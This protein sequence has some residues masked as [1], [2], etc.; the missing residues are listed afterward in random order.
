MGSVGDSIRGFLKDSNLGGGGVI[1]SPTPPDQ[2]RQAEFLRFP[3]QHF[4]AK[5]KRLCKSK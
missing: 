5:E 4:I 3:L 2:L 1:S